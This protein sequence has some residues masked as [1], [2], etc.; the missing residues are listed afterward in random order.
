MLIDRQF[1]DWVET[2]LK[3]D[4]SPVVLLP[5]SPVIVRNFFFLGDT[6][7]M[8]RLSLPYFHTICDQ[9]HEHVA[10]TCHT[11]EGQYV[12]ALAFSVFD[13]KP[14]ASVSAF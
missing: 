3:E 2:A 6:D 8:E 13:P 14:E 10:L 5:A 4:L 7:E 9:Y 1:I 11:H 12:R